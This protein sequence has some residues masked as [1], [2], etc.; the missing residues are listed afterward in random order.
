MKARAETFL[1]TGSR[2]Q[3]TLS[4]ND[5][6]LTAIVDTARDLRQSVV[7]AL[8]NDDGSGLPQILEQ[9]LNLIGSALNTQVGGS[10]VFGDHVSIRSRSPRR[11]WRTWSHCQR[12]RMRFRMIPSR[13]PRASR[14]A[15]RSNTA[16]SQTMSPSR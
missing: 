11:R 10:Y 2:V 4:T 14:T 16:W 1:R 8:A 12:Q 3:Q 7:E 9:S 5:I 15:W 13:R 6:Q